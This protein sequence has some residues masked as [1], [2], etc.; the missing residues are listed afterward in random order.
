MQYH[1]EFINPDGSLKENA[2]AELQKTG[3]NE[4]LS[5]PLEMSDKP[6]DR[7]NRES[8]IKG[9]SRAIEPAEIEIDVAD[10]EI[11]PGKDNPRNKDTV[12]T[13]KGKD[14]NKKDTT[15][16]ICKQT[17][18]DKRD[19]EVLKEKTWGTTEDGSELQETN[20]NGKSSIRQDGEAEPTSKRYTRNTANIS[21]VTFNVMVS[22]N[23]DENPTAL[24]LVNL[25]KARS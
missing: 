10:L 13:G 21:V 11:P 25:E 19:S 4:H 20:S 17:P 12:V 9:H 16:Q 24:D 14:E 18:T 23:T 7:R 6:V 22:E 15:D 1:Q 5:V 8:Q 2:V 3:T